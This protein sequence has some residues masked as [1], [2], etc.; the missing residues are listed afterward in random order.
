M[1]KERI[2]DTVMEGV[3]QRVKQSGMTYQEIGEKMGYS[4][5]SARQAVSQ[6]LRSGDPQISMLR[7]FA[8]AMEVSLQTLLKDK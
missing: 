5:S 1:G 8:E 6:F 2:E 4:Q 3:R 7:R